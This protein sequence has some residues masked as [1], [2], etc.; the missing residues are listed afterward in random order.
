MINEITYGGN[1]LKMSGLYLEDTLFH[2]CHL[3]VDGAVSVVR[4]NQI[5]NQ[6]F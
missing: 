3:P 1:T 4:D 6:Q 5:R 2:I